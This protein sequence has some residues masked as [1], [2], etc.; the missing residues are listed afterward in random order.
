MYGLPE[1]FDPTGFVGR[2]VEIVS[3]T[4]NTVHLA[5]DGDYSLTVESSFEHR[6][7]GCSN[8][9]ARFEVPVRDSGLM[10]LIGRPVVSAEVDKPGTLCL[11]FD[12]G[13]MFRCFDDSE[14][15]ESYK[16]NCGGTEIIV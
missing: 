13:Q 7:K 1:D 9:P 14:E 6:S 11:Q 10:S 16:V 2:S 8:Q 4:A 12:D 3:F 5:F 15:Y